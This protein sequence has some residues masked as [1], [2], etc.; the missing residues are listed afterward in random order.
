MASAMTHP[1]AP[2]LVPALPCSSPFCFQKEARAD[3]LGFL[4]K[5]TEL[6]GVAPCSRAS[7]SRTW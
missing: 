5:W 6:G 3:I 4:T 2:V 1:I 7:S